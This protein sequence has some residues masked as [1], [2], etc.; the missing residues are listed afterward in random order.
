MAIIP[1]SVWHC[2]RLAHRIL[3]FCVHLQ[4]R[5]VCPNTNRDAH[6]R[7]NNNKRK[8][9]QLIT[10][11]IKGIKRF[12]FFHSRSILHWWPFISV[13]DLRVFEESTTIT[14]TLNEIHDFQKISFFSPL[15]D[16]FWADGNNELNPYG[17]WWWAELIVLDLFNI[18]VYNVVHCISYISFSTIFPRVYASISVLHTHKAW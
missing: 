13:I 17:A 11:I 2:T 8:R 15:V 6:K 4:V 18:V 5:N 16:P 3:M 14:R 1:A 12:A 9:K 7:K 10:T